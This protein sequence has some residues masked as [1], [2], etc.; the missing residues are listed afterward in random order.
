M[1]L[2]LSSPLELIHVELLQSDN[3][4]VRAILSLMNLKELRISRIEG[5]IFWLGE[6]AYRNNR[7]IMRLNIMLD[8]GSVMEELFDEYDNFGGYAVIT[9]DSVENVKS[10]VIEV[11]DTY[12]GEKFDDICI[13]E[14]LAF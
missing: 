10:I 6:A 1:Y 11:T 7:R 9:F 2:D 3:R 14:V 4:K 8:T 13:S 5:Q 12:P